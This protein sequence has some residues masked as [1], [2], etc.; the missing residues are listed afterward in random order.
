MKKSGLILFFYFV[1]NLHLYGQKIITVA[2]NGSGGYHGDGGLATL[3][4]IGFFGGLA[5]D[6]HGNI[7]IADGN[8][9][10]IRKVDTAG[11]I[12]TI[13]GT[14]INGFTPDGAKSDTSKIGY[15][16]AVEVDTSGNIYF[17]DA[18]RIRKID[19]ITHIISTYVGTGTP[20]YSG[21]GHHADSAGVNIGEFIFDRFNN[22][23]LMDGPNYRIR[24]ID[25]SGI[26]STVAGT[27][28][29]GYSGDGGSALSA[30]LNSDFAL[31]ICTDDTGNVYFPDGNL[32]VRKYN[33]LTGIITRVAGK[34]DTVS[35]YSGEGGSAML[36]HFDV[37][38]V[39]VDDTGNIYIDDD[40]NNRIEKVDLHG[41]IRTIVG[42]GVAGYSGD[43]S[44]ADSAKINNPENIII[45][46]CNNLYIADF[47]NRRVRKVIF[48]STCGKSIGDT[49]THVVVNNIVANNDFEI[50]PNPARSS[51]QL[52]VGNWRSNKKNNY[53]I[54]DIMGRNMLEGNIAS[55][56]QLID[57]SGL[58]EGIYFVE[59]NN[60]GQRVIKKFVKE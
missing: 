25:A 14:G 58:I 36:A 23:Y 17:A 54:K 44:L 39:A 19:A 53:L 6:K 35:L 9:Y 4:T 48:D 31:G 55:F 20:G 16:G 10:R 41:T 27:G 56:R 18:G 37:Q 15:D 13:A 45:D 8:N 52:T 26:I 22:L 24:K 32:T 59:V 50:Y 47:A 1:C 38:A 11:I 43:G 2:G 28:V 42:N 49:N 46:K 5:V 21:D 57:I 7:Y 29:L 51:L 3:T 60:N 30:S 12:T 34:G 33:V 40:G